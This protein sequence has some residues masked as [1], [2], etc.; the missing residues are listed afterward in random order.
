[1]AGDDGAVAVHLPHLRRSDQNRNTRI[2]SDFASAHV[3]QRRF[4]RRHYGRTD[5]HRGEEEPQERQL[6]TAFAR[7]VD[8][9]SGCNNWWSH[10]RV[11]IIVLQPT[12]LFFYLRVVWTF[13]SSQFYDDT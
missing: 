13:S 11:R 7:V 8:C 1:M 4:H 9:W 5:G 12:C 6:R 3:V 10:W 2:R